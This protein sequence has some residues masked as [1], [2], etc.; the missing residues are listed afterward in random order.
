MFHSARA[1]GRCRHDAQCSAQRKVPSV[2][3]SSSRLPFPLLSPIVSDDLQLRFGS[4]SRQTRDCVPRPCVACRNL[5]RRGAASSPDGNVVVPDVKRNFVRSTVRAANNPGDTARINSA[6]IGAE[7]KATVLARGVCYAS[8]DCRIASY[9]GRAVNGIVS[10]N[11]AS[12]CV[13]GVAE[14]VPPPFARFYSV[15]RIGPLQGCVIPPND[16]RGNCTKQAYAHENGIK[17]SH[18]GIDTTLCA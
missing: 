5:K 9:L 11:M 2:R 1:Q 17:A 8:R 6:K 13:E 14:V 3:G 16:R 7:L 10:G 15:T 18:T 4:G 12:L